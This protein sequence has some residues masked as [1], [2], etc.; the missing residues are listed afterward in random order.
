MLQGKWGEGVGRDDEL[1]MLENTFMVKRFR[2]ATYTQ[3]ISDACNLE[4]GK[5][6]PLG[7]I[8]NTLTFDL[9]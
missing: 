1:F 6:Q 2:R 4:S 7:D 8:L 3:L 9:L 5:K